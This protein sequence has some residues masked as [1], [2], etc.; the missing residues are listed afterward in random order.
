MKAV[1]I[2]WDTDGDK[3][4]LKS[5]PQKLKFPTTLTKKISGIISQT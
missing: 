3:S 2:M 5:C 4:F 1:N